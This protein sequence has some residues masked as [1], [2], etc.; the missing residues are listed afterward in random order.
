VHRRR[1]AFGGQPV[2]TVPHVFDGLY[3]HGAVAPMTDARFV[4]ARPA[5]NTARV[6]RVVD[7][8]APAFPDS[9]YRLRLDNRGRHWVQWLGLPAH[10]RFVC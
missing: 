10:E 7:P 8:Y 6:Q 3:G 4:L 1:T 2:G 9:L 5:L